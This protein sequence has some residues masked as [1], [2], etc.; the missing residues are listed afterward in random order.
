MALGGQSAR[1]KRNTMKIYVIRHAEAIEKGMVADELRHLTSEGRA[2]FRRVCRHFD[3]KGMS[4]DLILSS[5]LVRAVQTAEI[6]A[7]RLGF[8]GEVA[9]V[10][11]LAEMLDREQLA[12]LLARWPEARKVALVGHEPYLGKL[13]GELVG[14]DAGF[15]FEKGAGIALSYAP[16][17]ASSTFRWYIAGKKK[18]TDLENLFRGE[19]EERPPVRKR[20][21]KCKKFPSPPE[22]AVAAVPPAAPL[23]AA[24]M[25]EGDPII[26]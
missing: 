18:V 21:G 5:P 3:H 1:A 7:A 26:V 6:L 10:P 16:D 4:V 13:V 2:F 9:A 25:T 19:G 14:R 17:R 23:P 15:V 12:S 20:C 11:E 24:A 22:A 8:E